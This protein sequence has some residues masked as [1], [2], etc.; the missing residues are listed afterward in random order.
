MSNTKEIPKVRAI[1][2]YFHSTV[3]STAEAFSCCSSRSN[4]DMLRVWL[5]C[6]QF[7]PNERGVKIVAALEVCTKD[8]Q[9]AIVS[10]G[11]RGAETNRKLSAKYGQNCLPQ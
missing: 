5:S 8:K 3:D 11:M 1:L 10:E 2:G 6:S 4:G 9:R 7:V